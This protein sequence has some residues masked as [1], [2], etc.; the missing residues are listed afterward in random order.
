MTNDEVRSQEKVCAMLGKPRLALRAPVSNA[1]INQ[2]P[3]CF[4]AGRTEVSLLSSPAA[5]LQ[6][7]ARCA[8]VDLLKARFITE[9]TLIISASIISSFSKES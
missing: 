8:E 2:G 1:S 3:G 7:N 5:R 6:Q 9:L 4:S